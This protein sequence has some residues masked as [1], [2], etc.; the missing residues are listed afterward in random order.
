[1]VPAVGPTPNRVFHLIRKSGDELRIP[2]QTICDTNGYGTSFRFKSGGD[3]VGHADGDFKAWWVND[4]DS[5][6]KHLCFELDAYG[7]IR[8]RADSKRV[9]RDGRR[10]KIV[11][12]CEGEWQ[13]KS[14]PTRSPPGSKTSHRQDPN[15]DSHPI[16]PSGRPTPCR[17]RRR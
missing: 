16:A 8:V 17:H 2:A 12:E 5:H 3:V 6:G 9:D 7:I 4:S 15:R 14:L 11:L 1:M 13:A 10:P